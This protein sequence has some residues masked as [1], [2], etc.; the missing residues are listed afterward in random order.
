MRNNAGADVTIG[1]GPESLRAALAEVCALGGWSTGPGGLVLACCEGGADGEGPIA[2]RIG[3]APGP[4]IDF[5][6]PGDEPALLVALDH[7]LAP[8][9]GHVV[10][11]RGLAGGVGT[12]LLAA[13]LA[14]RLGAVLVDADPAGPGAT[15][16]VGIDAVA[17]SVSDGGVLAA[18]T[19]TLSSWGPVRVARVEGNVEA[20]CAALARMCA[21][22]VCDVGRGSGWGD[23]TVGVGRVGVVEAATLSRTGTPD[24]LA[25]VDTRRRCRASCRVVPVPSLTA[26][27]RS[28]GGGWGPRPTSSRGFARCLRQLE[29]EV[30][31]CVA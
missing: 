6:I 7:A 22:V 21:W 23:V 1:P 2:F 4:G 13:A 24:V 12:S 20:A 26:P 19:E 30:R 8:S 17:L 15:H 31:A 16:L 27:I 10:T 18:A 3:Q 9:A 28:I 25:L 11:V 29:R 14:W 5:V